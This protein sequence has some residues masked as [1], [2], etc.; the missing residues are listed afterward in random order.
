MTISSEL[1]DFFNE[2]FAEVAAHLEFLAEMGLAAQSG[3]PRIE[4]SPARVTAE[5]Q[6]ILYSGIYLQLYNLVEATVSRC[7]SAV[8]A[9]ASDGEWKPQDLNEALKGEWVRVSARTHIV[10]TPENRLQ[11]AIAMCAY[12]VDQLPVE[13]FAVDTGGGG[14][15]DDKGIEKLSARLGCQFK[16]SRKAKQA[17]KRPVRDDMGALALV[18]NRRNQLAHGA[19]S[20]AEC[21]DGVTVEDLRGLVEAVGLYLR[22]ALRCFVTYIDGHHFLRPESI[23]AGA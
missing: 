19:I 18:K 10:L 11:S 23:P 5:Q 14:N 21:A 7:V 6:K 15:W 20:F 3:P 13:D 12:L 2:R 22:E 8:T 17:A 1:T 9:A 16:I 4:G